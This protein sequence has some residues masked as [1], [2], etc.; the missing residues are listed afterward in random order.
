MA[1]QRRAPLTRRKAMQ[2]VAP[3]NGAADATTHFV[4]GYV[5]DVLFAC[6]IPA[7]VHHALKQHAVKTRQH[8]KD[9]ATQI[10]RHYLEEH[11]ELLR[12][13]F[14]GGRPAG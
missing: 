1:T 9:L 8:V 6:R 12:G 13:G 2:A 11:G 4:E 5:P 10:L 3:T 7:P 14:V